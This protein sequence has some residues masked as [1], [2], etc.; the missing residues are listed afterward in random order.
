VQAMKNQITSRICAQ[1]TAVS[2]EP[3]LEQA[4]LKLRPVCNDDAAGIMEMHS[5]LSRDSIYLRYLHAYQPS[6]EQIENMLNAVI[7]SGSGFVAVNKAGETIGLGYYIQDKADQNVAEPALI[8]ED[9][10]QGQGVGSAMMRS[11]SQQADQ[12]GL[13]ALRAWIDPANRRVLHMARKLGYPAR[14]RFVD[15]MIEADLILKN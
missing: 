13:R 4:E 5:R 10:Y 12:A 14:T 15:G 11:L 6:V 2:Y 8:V 1:F 7:S 9:R 3:A